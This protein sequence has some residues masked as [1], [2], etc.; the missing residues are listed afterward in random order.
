MRFD[1][2]LREE[3]KRRYEAAGY[4]R[5]RT[6]LHA[7]DDVVRLRP[8]ATA[9]VSPNGRRLSF[10]ELDEASRRVAAN[11]AAW[12]VGQGD[13]ISVQLPNWAEFVVVHLAATRVGAVTNPLLPIY[14]ESELSYILA[15]AKAK[16]AL[17]P[18]QYR[19]WDYPAMYQRMRASLP[20]LERVVVVGG[21]AAAGMR[22]YAELS[23]ESSFPLP[24]LEWDANDVSVVV[25]TSG[26]ESKPKGVMHSHNTMMYATQAMPE[27]LGLTHE[28]TV[29]VPSPVGHGTG[30]VWGM[31]QALV[32]GSKMVLQDIWD[33][34]EALRLIEAE[35]CAFTLSATP[36]V[37]MLLDCPAV[38]HRD[39]SSFRY[40]GCAGAP[41]PRHLGLEAKEK[42][43]C[44]LIGMWGMSECF[45]G[46]SSRADD[47]E[48]KRWGTD[49][50]AMPGGEL[51]IFDE[52]HTRILACGE[53]G[54]L[55]TRGPHVALG[56]FNDPQ[57]TAQAFSPD[58]WLFTNDLAVMDAEG[59]MRIVG[60]RKDII[61]RGG[62]KVSAREVEELLGRH[63]LVNDVA[64]VAV[65]DDRL[66]EKGCVFVIPAGEAQPTLREL[67]DYLE[68][69]GIAKYKLPEFLVMLSE[70][71]MTPTGK[72]QK[73]ALRDAVIEGRYSVHIV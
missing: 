32:L 47:P 2:L 70:F 7:L 60:R 48:E 62:L 15:F 57:R 40:F 63:P 22:D 17:I 37:K 23:A 54:E 39:T 24:A 65:P 1:T 12:G 33:P 59:Y 66:G 35:R 31:R 61:N 9:V 14:R 5:G 18:G 30:F 29:W 72:V 50:R 8:D 38:Q 49:G 27:L 3:S 41:I 20:D 13:V 45:V 46:S 25:F 68:E 26:T 73:F 36:F 71:P 55:A 34:E 19:G 69:R 52:T 28:D 11:L 43:G 4:W 67:L 44:E 53:V 6:L 58:G 64:V 10:A 21:E 51:A 56:Y 16:V 42:L